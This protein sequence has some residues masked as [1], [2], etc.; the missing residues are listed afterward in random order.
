[1]R[2]SNRRLGMDLF[3][4]GFEAQGVI[5]RRLTVLAAGGPAARDE[6]ARMVGEK[7]L[8]A[9]DAA[10]TLASGGTAREVVRNYRKKV[11]ANAR[12]L[13]RA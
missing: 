6:A 2:R 12:R 9:G 11:R 5:A 7:V 8:A 3:R 10:L 1:M 13:D 4:L